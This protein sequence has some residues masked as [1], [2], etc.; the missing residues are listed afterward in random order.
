VLYLKNSF[1]EFDAGRSDQEKWL[2]RLLQIMSEFLDIGRFFHL[3]EED[4]KEL[5]NYLYA[6]NIL[7][8][9]I[10]G[11]SVASPKLRNQIIDNLLLPLGRIPSEL[12]EA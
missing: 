10:G 11:D 6:C 4:T 2:E 9:C 12:L 8:D 3:N 1:P 5:N 7:V